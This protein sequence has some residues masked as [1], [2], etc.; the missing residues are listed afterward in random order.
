MIS[1]EIDADKLKIA[2]RRKIQE[3][4]G[5]EYHDEGD[6]VPTYVL[7]LLLKGI[8][9]NAMVYELS[10]FFGKEMALAYTNWL[11]QFVENMT[12]KTTSI[13]DYDFKSYIKK[14]NSHMGEKVQSLVKK[15][16]ISE[17]S[18]KISSSSSL[19]LNSRTHQG[20]QNTI[21][22]RPVFG[23]L[24]HA[25]LYDAGKP[26]SSTTLKAFKK[27]KQLNTS[28]KKLIF[29]SH[30]FIKRNKKINRKILNLS[31]IAN[32]SNVIAR[33]LS[34]SKGFNCD[35]HVTSTFPNNN[36]IDKTNTRKPFLSTQKVIKEKFHPW[37]KSV[38]A[39]NLDNYVTHH[40]INE[41]F[42]GIGTVCFVYLP[43]N[44]NGSIKSYSIIVFDTKK[45]AANAL[46]LDG[47]LIKGKLINVK[48]KVIT[49][50]HSHFK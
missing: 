39:S 5:K 13:K 26:V 22:S 19:T 21:L 7:A 42:K 41:H 2:I 33:S 24:L 20:S 44:P 12:K 10:D 32:K 29:D 47:S 31:Q 17:P 23:R 25:A 43:R 9:V 45:E 16:L 36:K 48:P 49:T 37:T 4:Y 46:T 15:T 18:D 3:Y 27:T 34:G 1:S 8:D 50:A 35:R 30:H 11:I 28:E 38:I 14:P 40:I 6:T